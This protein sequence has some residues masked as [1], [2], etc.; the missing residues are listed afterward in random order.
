M[1]VTKW[2]GRKAWELQ[3][4]KISKEGILIQRILT[5]NEIKIPVSADG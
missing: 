4:E 1:E 2:T 5:P 3:L